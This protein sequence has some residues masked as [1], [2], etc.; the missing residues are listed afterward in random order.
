MRLAWTWLLSI[1][2]ALPLKAETIRVAVARGS[3]LELKGAELVCRSEPDAPPVALGAV[4]KFDAVGPFVSSGE[5]LAPALGV[6]DR[7]GAPIRVGTVSLLGAAQV[8]AGRDGLVAID[9]VD[10]ETYVASVVGS[11]MSASWPAAALEAQAIAARTYVLKKKA[12]AKADQPYD[13]E[14]TVMHQVYKG[15]QSI[16]ARTAAAAEKTRGVVLDWDGQLADAFFF[17]SCSGK[18]E[19]ALAAFG[20]G[21]PYLVPT[22][23]EGGEQ[24][25]K[26]RWTQRLSFA[27]LSSAL[28][29]QALVADEVT[30]LEVSKRTETGRIAQSRATLRNGTKVFIPGADL[31][32]AIGYTVMQSLDAELSTKGDDVV[33][34]GRGAGHGVGLCQWC[35]KGR[36]LAGDS[37]ETI[38]ARAYPGTT[39]KR[40]Y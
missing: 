27:K 14:A 8:V 5:Q 18:T 1:T 7:T 4:A 22:S 34:T 2:L 40:I 39:L 3:T 23:C 28:K 11:E 13:V 9:H 6:E 24:A 37:A 20:S 17:A 26:L 33:L 19:S 15:A 10:V 12:A 31:R 25:P 38:L 16:D 21:Q 36:A 35:A 29:A 30:H 32:R